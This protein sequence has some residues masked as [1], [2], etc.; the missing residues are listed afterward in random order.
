MELVRDLVPNLLKRKGLN[1]EYRIIQENDTS[2]FD[3]IRDKFVGVTGEAARAIKSGNPEDVVIALAAV[4]EI[5]G[6]AGKQYNISLNQIQEARNLR[7]K[8]KG[9]YEEFFVLITP[10][11]TRL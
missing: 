7:R 10:N 8:L 2:R 9:G 11:R 4:M 3:I 6:L 5:V 1:P